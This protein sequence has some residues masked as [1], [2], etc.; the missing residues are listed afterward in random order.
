MGDKMLAGFIIP[1]PARP[2]SKFESW[3][4]WGPRMRAGNAAWPDTNASYRFRVQRVVPP[5]PAPGPEVVE[6]QQF[7]S[8]KP[9]APL[10]DWL[11]FLR[12]EAPEE[13]TQAILNLAE[14]RPAELADEI[15]ST[16][17]PTR[18]AALTVAKQ[19]KNVTPE[20]RDA[21]IAE[22]KNIT[23]GLRRFNTMKSDDPNFWSAQRELHMRFAYW[24]QA[25]WSVH[26]KL[27]L[28][29]R[30]PVQEMHDLALVRAEDTTMDELVVNAKAI[31]N[32]LNPLA[33]TAP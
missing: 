9:E 31:L 21:I 7:A 13:R 18:E 8:L 5:P 2:G 30:P 27:G 19:M 28:D 22:G 23:E 32:A 17:A 4:E 20:I 33:Q 14:Q 3:S 10:R 25:W 1:L 26:K 24:K 12:P 15:F 6:A 29:G 11:A 16:N